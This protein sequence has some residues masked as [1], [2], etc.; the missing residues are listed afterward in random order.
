[1]LHNEDLRHLVRQLRHCVKRDAC[2]IMQWA[3]VPEA[4]YLQTCKGGATHPTVPEAVKALIRAAGNGNSGNGKEPL[5]HH[6]LFAR[7]AL[8]QFRSTEQRLTLRPVVDFLTNSIVV[9]DSKSEQVAQKIQKTYALCNT[10]LYFHPHLQDGIGLKQLDVQRLNPRND[11]WTSLF[12]VGTFVFQ[13][14]PRGG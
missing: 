5:D 12:S 8:S 14:G 6:E 9:L 7:L 2:I 3:N 10:T 4:P 1:M 13:D 11:S